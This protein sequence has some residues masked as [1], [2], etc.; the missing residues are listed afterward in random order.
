MIHLRTSPSYLLGFLSALLFVGATPSAQ[1]APTVIELD[2]VGPRWLGTQYLDNLG[3]NIESPGDLTYDGLSDF[4]VSS[5]QDVGPLT[6]DSVLRIFYGDEQGAPVSGAADWEDVALVDGRVGTDAVYQFTFIPDTNGDGEPDLL[7][8]EPKAGDAGKVLLYP[9]GPKSLAALTGSPDAL[10]R[11]TGFLQDENS[12]LP[13]ATRPSR[14]AGGDLDGDGFADIVIASDLFS[15]VWVD[16][17]EGGFTGERSLA[18]LPVI[19]QCGQEIPAAHFGESIAVGDFNADGLDDLAVGGS[20]CAAGAGRVFV[21]YGST[22]G[23]SDNPDLTLS[24][25]VRLGSFLHVIDLDGDDVDDLAVQELL[26]ET[27]GDE[28]AEGR[29]NLWVF[30][31][32]TEGLGD[33]PTVK[34]FGSF[35]DQRFGEDVAMLGDISSPPDGLDEL[36]ISAPES[37]ISGTGQ[38]TVYIFEG[39]EDWSGEVTVSEATYQISGAHR[40]AWLGH[41]IATMD[42]F[43]GDGYPELLIGEPN[44]TEGEAENDFKRGRLYMVTALPERDEDGDGITTVAGDCDDLDPAVSTM[45]WEECD[46]GIDNDCDHLIDE[47]CDDEKGD[48]DDDDDIPWEPPVAEEGCDCESSMVGST[49]SG[50]GVLFGMIALLALRRRHPQLR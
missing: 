47:G 11:W 23:L 18:D 33:S 9:G 5:P 41:S 49:R 28:S 22:W 13:A 19:R 8:A 10:A 31:G 21:W 24:G 1:A 37:A 45:T 29:G 39:R 34:V 50:L 27:E 4:A 26:S 14:V 25:G 38:G 48:D 7:V 16:Y 43:N 2:H 36:V 35:S 6:F 15:A 17:S 30:A 42:D 3:W 20:G 32:G 44:Y 40:D 46:D 12:Q